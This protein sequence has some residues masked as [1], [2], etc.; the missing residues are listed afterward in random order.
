M[1]PVHAISS[2]IPEPGPRRPYSLAILI[3]TFGNGLLLVS[4]PLYF[5]R[6]V[7]LSAVQVGLG[8]TIAATVTLMT[9][10]PLGQLADRRGPLKVAK[11][12]LL[13]QCAATIAFL[14]INNFATFVAA[15]IVNTLAARAI[16]AAEGAL[17]RRLAGQEAAGYRSSLHALTNVGLSLGVASCGIAI[18]LDTATAYRALI[19]VDALTFLGAWIVL[20]RLPRYEPLPTPAAEPRWGVLRDKPFAV[21]AVLMAAS[22][23]QFSVITL[24]L[25]LWVIEYTDAPRWCIPLAL[26]FNTVL[27]VLFQVRVGSGVQTILQG[28]DAWRRAHVA[29][30]FSC[31]VISLATGVPAWVALLILVAGVCLHTLGEMWH[32]SSIFALHLGFPPPHAQGQYDGFLGTIAG[33]GAA[34]AP[35]VLLGPVLGFGRPGLIGLGV[36]FV[37]TGLLMPPVARWGKRTRPAPSDSPDVEPTAVPE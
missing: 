27:V 2:L 31:V 36:F 9:S 26:V 35:A 1:N 20:R 34:A 33:L 11:A 25:P 4:M 14:F 28:G 10:L 6:V 24:L 29:F 5:T 37:L 15:A 22:S 32:M 19:V 3:N 18:Q 23:L 12:M 13:L 16:G 8:L 7:E 30:L 21:F 17:L